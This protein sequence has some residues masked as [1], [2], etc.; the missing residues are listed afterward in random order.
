MKSNKQFIFFSVIFISLYVG[1][2]LLADF[3][4]DIL[5]KYISHTMDHWR[6]SRGSYMTARFVLWDVLIEIGLFTIV[7]GYVSRNP[8]SFVQFNAFYKHENEHFFFVFIRVLWVSLATSFVLMLVLGM[9]QGFFDGL[10]QFL[11][12]QYY[13]EHLREGFGIVDG[14]SPVENKISPSGVVS[15]WGIIYGT[16]LPYVTSYQLFDYHFGFL[17][18]FN[19]SLLFVLFLRIG[20][21]TTL[22]RDLLESINL[23]VSSTKVVVALS[24]IFLFFSTDFTQLFSYQR[25]KPTPK[26]IEEL[27]RE[28]NPNSNNQ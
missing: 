20:I 6:D 26:P 3:G 10:P 18:A 28:L 25:V 17:K 13:P 9:I 14:I 16:K 21:F 23:K 27:Y 24:L 2:S 8:L 15:T 1:L 19:F 5:A 22:F 7:V 4:G 11:L 12:W